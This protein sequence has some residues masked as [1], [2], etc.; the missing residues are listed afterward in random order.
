MWFTGLNTFAFI[1]LARRPSFIKVERLPSCASNNQ[2]GRQSLWFLVRKKPPPLWTIWTGTNVCV[3]ACACVRLCVL[4]VL[5]QSTVQLAGASFAPDDWFLFR[6]MPMGLIKS[7]RKL[8]SV[9]N[10]RENAVSMLS[11]RGG[12]LWQVKTQRALHTALTC[13]LHVSFLILEKYR[14]S[15]FLFICHYSLDCVMDHFIFYL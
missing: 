1:Q 3:Y 12:E 9:T 14:I 8:T 13:S 10:C 4:A 5:I 2:T 7:K 11:L 15:T 6:A